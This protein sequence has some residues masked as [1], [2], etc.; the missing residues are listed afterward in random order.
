MAGFID[1]I[2]EVLSIELDLGGVSLS[3]GEIALGYILLRYGSSFF[4]DLTGHDPID[5][6]LSE[7][8]EIIRQQQREDAANY[9]NILNRD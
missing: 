4:L 7:T 2:V 8:D 3:L 9:S 6:Y 1:L 5:A